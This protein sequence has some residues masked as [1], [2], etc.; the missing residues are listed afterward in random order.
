M[1]E[2]QAAKP[3]MVPAGP[4]DASGSNAPLLLP[5]VPAAI[6]LPEEAAGRQSK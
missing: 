1:V 5:T 6:L 2:V 4:T 3:V